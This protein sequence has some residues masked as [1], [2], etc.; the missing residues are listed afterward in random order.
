MKRSGHL[1]QKRAGL[2]HVRHTLR[3]WGELLRAAVLE[4]LETGT[5]SNFQGSFRWTVV[6][7]RLDARSQNKPP[8]QHCSSR[9]RLQLNHSLDVGLILAVVV[10][11]QQLSS[12]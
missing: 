6:L 4:A 5:G 2:S 7:I 12:M 9:P 1:G 3:L 8:D 10:C 11:C